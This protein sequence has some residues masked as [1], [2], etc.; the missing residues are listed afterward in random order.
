M[1]LIQALVPSA[2]RDD[3]LFALDTE[4]IDYVTLRENTDGENSVIVQFPLPTQA[5]EEVLET[6]EEAGVDD[7]FI[8]VS[9]IETARTPG[10]ES[11]E[12][13]FVS[14]SESDDSIFYE[15]IRTRALN[16]TPNRLTYYAMTLLSAV[17]A[18]AGLLLDSPAIVVGSMVIAPQ[19]SAALTGTVGMVLN[20]RGMIVDGISSLV[21]GLVAAM[22]GA[23][24]FAWLLRSGAI[25][26]ST[27]EITAIH[28]V[29]TRISPDLL[30]LIIGI[31]AGAAG[32]FGLATALP[33]SLVG[34][35]I[36]AAL[37]PAAAAVGI[38]LAWNAPLVAAGAF[39][40]LTIN[41]ASIVLSGLAVFWYLGYRPADWVPGDLG[42]NLTRD[43]LGAIVPAVL[44]LS[45][46]CLLAGGVLFHHVS[47]ENDVNEEIRTV[48]DNPEYDRLELVDLRTEF[49]GGD[50]AT[51]YEVTAVVRRPDGVAYPD[52][53]STLEDA[54]EDR[55]GRQIEVTVEYVDRDTGTD[56]GEAR[57]DSVNRPMTDRGMPGTQGV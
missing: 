42:R 9:S 44:V 7:D 10:L 13:R 48:L 5:V 33:V 15:E 1:R 40:L 35:M 2:V 46:V 37:I 55:T 6:L 12:E 23:F 45:L 25:V 11:L 16:M 20:D 34:V 36:A 28:Q 30:S 26:P 39:V 57:F 29:S 47:F 3:V 49:V 31:C 50:L 8:V 17:V 43:R 56:R 27:I 38:G 32:A 18:T 21:G 54:L 51:S 53:V 14:G 24:A 52:L 41:A 19:V 22:A 4:G